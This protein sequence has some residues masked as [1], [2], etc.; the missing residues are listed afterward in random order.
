MKLMCHRPR[1]Q[2]IGLDS[3]DRELQVQRTSNKSELLEIRKL[4]KA[5]KK[6]GCPWSSRT[7]IYKG[8]QV[9][10][11]DSFYLKIE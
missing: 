6:E 3:T 9:E 5:M 2:R 8:F 4:A 7:Y 1:T 11:N 10:P